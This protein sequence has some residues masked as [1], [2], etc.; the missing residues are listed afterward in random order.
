MFVFF[1]YSFLNASISIQQQFGKTN[2][3]TE[4]PKSKKKKEFFF[5][6][7]ERKK[8]RTESVRVTRQSSVMDEKGKIPRDPFTS[9]KSEQT[10][11][12]DELISFPHGGRY[13]WNADD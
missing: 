4:L 3:T 5:K 8:E 9:L 1:F 10:V 2:F 7:K 12:S 6:K 13:E 11:D